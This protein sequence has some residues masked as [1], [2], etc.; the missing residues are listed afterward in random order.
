MVRYYFAFI[1]SLF[2]EVP[3]MAQF[4]QMRVILENQLED[5]RSSLITDLDQDGDLDIIVATD[6]PA[7]IVWYEHRD[8]GTFNDPEVLLYETS[9]WKLALGDVDADGDEDLVGSSYGPNRLMWWPRNGASFG[10]PQIIDTSINQPSAMEVTDL[11]M[12]GDLDMVITGNADQT[13]SLFEGLGGG[14]FGPRQI[15]ATGL[16][17]HRSARVG[18]LDG[19]GAADIVVATYYGNNITWHRNSGDLTFLPPVT[20]NAQVDS[21]T[22]I[23]LVD[24]NGDGSLDLVFPAPATDQVVWQQNNGD[25]TFGAVHVIGWAMNNAVSIQVRDVDVDGDL[26]VVCTSSPDDRV[27]MLQNNGNGTYSYFLLNDIAVH[28][29]D[30]K[31]IDMDGDGLS[32]VFYMG[33]GSD[34]LVWHKNLGSGAFSSQIQITRQVRIPRSIISGDLDGDGDEDVIYASSKDHRIA[35]QENLGAGEF[36]EQRNLFLGGGTCSS[37]AAADINGDGYLDLLTAQQPDI[38]SIQKGMAGVS[39]EPP[40]VINSPVNYYTELQCH[41]LDA[42]GDLDLIASATSL[43]IYFLNNGDGTFASGVTFTSLITGDTYFAVADLDG[44]DLLDVVQSASGYGWLAWYRNLGGGTFASR[45]S[46]AEG[47]SY[48]ERLACG[49][50]NGDGNVDIVA[51]TTP[52]RWYAGNGDGTFGTHTIL[53]SDNAY[54]C[55][56]LLAFDTDGDGDDDVISSHG[57][58]FDPGYIQIYRSNGDGTF[59]PGAIIANNIE[60]AIPLNKGNV[61]GNGSM[62]LLGCGTGKLFWFSNYFN[63]KYRILGK[64]FHDVDGNGVFDPSEPPLSWGQAQVVPNLNSALSGSDGSYIFYLDTGTFQVSSSSANGFWIQSTQPSTYTVTL[65]ENSPE[66]YGND[67]GFTT[68][69]DTSLVVP[70]ITVAAAPCGGRTSM[71]INYTNQGTRIESGTVTV[72]LDENYTFVSSDPAPASIQGNSITWV[73]DSLGYFGVGNIHLVIDMPT[74]DLMGTELITTATVSTMWNGAPSGEFS[75]S[76]ESVLACSYDP[77][78]KQVEPAGYGQFGSI[79]MDTEYLDYTIRFQNTGTAQA[80]NV[81]LRDA[82]PALTD[83]T[84]FTIL[85]YSHQPTHVA[86]EPGHELVVKFDDIMLPPSYISEENSQGFIKFRLP[87]QPGLPHLTEF[88]NTAEIFFDLNPPIITNTTTSTLV[89][90]DLWQPVVEE[91][92]IELLQASPGDAYQ[93]LLDGSPIDGGTDFQL[94]A[95]ETGE[96]SCE[97]TSIHGCTAMTDPFFLIVTSMQE[98]SSMEFSVHPNPFNDGF[99]LR[100]HRPLTADHEV[101]LF[102]LQGRE[103]RSMWGMGSDLLGVPRNGLSAGVYLLRMYE[104]GSPVGDLRI[105]AQ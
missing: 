10:G 25:G 77:N 68:L 98:W 45:V 18:D 75:T 52:L 34:D 92:G 84:Q 87:L 83:V 43:L 93:W 70:T 39:F 12:D 35:W 102:D 17:Q 9:V 1:V 101:I 97:V 58:V 19:D 20:I 56:G 96:Y 76:F 62:E 74:V 30:V 33:G 73:F 31:L 40:V 104:R 54:D 3:T 57:S 89:N 14:E 51:G 63:S 61:R 24:M 64:R 41:D 47:V 100:S 82:L 60:G 90:C 79:A 49:D 15:L 88:Q 32:D 81:M 53:G 59:M 28:P 36:G 69:V 94:Q 105:V 86:L 27:Q 48:I 8:D 22:C 91:V 11:D 13:L 67:L 99:V 55:Y 23:E 50:I 42:D 26:D 21:L 38:I 46:I 103:L 80:F 16:S 85:G 6:H 65:T 44:D 4:G 71:W 78:D 37:V 95:P 66:S 7:G 29:F 5:P 72:E 2:L